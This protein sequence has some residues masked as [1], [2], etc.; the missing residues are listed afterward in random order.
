MV[1]ELAV[2]NKGLNVSQAEELVRI[3]HSGRMKVSSY[4][5]KVEGRWQELIKIPVTKSLTVIE[6]PLPAADSAM[7]RCSECHVNKL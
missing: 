4:F 1:F 7:I 3:V 5:F 2:A 6:A